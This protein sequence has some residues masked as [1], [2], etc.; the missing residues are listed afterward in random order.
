MAIA[1]S[2]SKPFSKGDASF[3]G[4]MQFPQSRKVYVT[5]SKPDI[6][7]GMREIAQ[8][9]TLDDAGNVPAEN[10]PITVYDTSGPYSDPD[11]SLDLRC[12]LPPLRHSWLEKR[13][14]IEVVESKKNER[15]AAFPESRPVLRARPGGGITQLYYAK[16]GIVTEEMEYAALRENMRMERYPEFLRRAAFPPQKEME[17][18]TPELV[19]EEV[20]RGR[21]IIPANINHPELEPMVIGRRFAVKINANIGNSALRGSI[22]EEVEKMVWAIHWGADTVMDLSTGA[23]IHDT[24]EWIIRN[25]PVPLGSVPI[26]QA[27]EKTDGNVE[28]LTWEIVRD[29]LVE[30]AEQGIDYFTLHAAALKDHFPLVKTR[31]TG[32]VSRGGAIMARWCIAHNKENFLYEHWD[33]VCDILAAYDVG[34]S[35]GDGLRPGSIHDANDAAQFAELKTQGDLTRRAWAK[36]VQVMNEGPGHVPMHLIEENMKNQLDWC[37]EAPFYTLGPLPTDIAAGYDHVASTLGGAMIGMNGASMLCYVTP[38]EHLGLPDKQDVRE[39]VVT[40]KLAAHAADVAKGF[41]GAHIRDN[42]MSKARY[43]FRWA[44]QIAL[45][46][47][48]ER[49]REL[50]SASFPAEENLPEGYCS[51][52]G[53]NFC[54]MRLYKKI[55]PN[56]K[57]SDNI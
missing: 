8:H 50:R 36:Y 53:P 37:D 39:G 1:F 26:Y 25:S 34:V 49:C 31:L 24:R 16:R 6:R 20:A 23:D 13:E 9:A 19:R 32:I 43:E 29:T 10:P 7:V 28:A 33:E 21:A 22:E 54:S 17:S 56:S 2:D 40:H 57:P 38:K 12:G 27:L 55:C 47:D 11:I 41:P 46:L 42:A 51:M 35:I 3:S 18:I 4:F 44:D 30:Q 14:N 45:S 48:P 52:C 5:G 15:G